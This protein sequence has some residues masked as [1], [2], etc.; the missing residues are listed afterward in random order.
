MIWVLAFSGCVY[1]LILLHRPV[2]YCEDSVYCRE[3]YLE[4]FVRHLTLLSMV[5]VGLEGVGWAIMFFSI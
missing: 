3:V 5:A 4:S 2:T 1:M